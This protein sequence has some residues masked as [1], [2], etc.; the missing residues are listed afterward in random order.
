MPAAKGP[1]YRIARAIT[2]LEKAPFPASLNA[3][4]VAR[5]SDGPARLRARPVLANAGRFPKVTVKALVAGGP[6]SAAMTRTT[7][8]ATTLSASPAVNVIASRA[9]AGLNIRIAPGESVDS[10]VEHVRRAIHDKH[11]TIR[12]IEGGDP[13][14]VSPFDADEAFGLLERTI[15]EVFPDAVPAPYVLMAAT[16]SRHFTR[17]SDRVYRFAPFRMTKAQRQAIHSYDER[18][19]VDDYLDGVRWYHRLIERLPR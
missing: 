6:E 18:L 8:A 11:V 12:V 10:V 2:R 16:D 17:I 3:P 7:L 19:G 4:T 5:P 1:T 15:G 14:P 9:T 13:S